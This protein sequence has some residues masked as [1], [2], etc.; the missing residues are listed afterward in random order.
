MPDFRD[1][2]EIAT[3]TTV[4]NLMTGSPFE[5]VGGRGARVTVYMASDEATAANGALVTATVILGSDIL[6]RDG[7][8]TTVGTGLELRVPDHLFASGIAAP[9][10]PITVSVTNGTAA[11]SGV[12]TLVRIENL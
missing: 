1:T 6:V 5:R 8:P 11:T 4:A 2:R 3:V 9:G 7:N 10:D 12:A